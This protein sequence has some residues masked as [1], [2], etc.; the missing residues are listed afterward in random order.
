MEDFR[1]RLLDQF[2]KHLF[3]N[4]EAY[5]TL[6]EMPIDVDGFITYLI[7]H[8]LIQ[9]TTIKHY[10]VLHEFGEH[11]PKQKNHKTE[12]VNILANRFNISVRS[13]WSIL[14]NGKYFDGRKH[15]P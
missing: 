2:H 3:H 1:K 11:L 10:T 13:I 6:H 15:Q 8:D 7:D 12:T 9:K 4:Y 14:K 5:C